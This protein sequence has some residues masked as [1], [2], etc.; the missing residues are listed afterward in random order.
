MKGE[1]NREEEI[2]KNN[3]CKIGKSINR[4]KEAKKEI[5]DIKESGFFTKLFKRGRLNHLEAEIRSLEK[6]NDNTSS[7]QSTILKR[8]GSL[9]FK[10]KSIEE[11]INKYN[12]QIRNLSSEDLKSQID[13]SINDLDILKRRCLDGER[14]IDDVPKVVSVNARII[15]ATLS[16]CHIDNDIS[17]TNFDRV[18][19][20]EASM[21]SLPLLFF[22]GFRATKSICIFGDPKQLAP[23]CI[24]NKE[25]VRKWFAKDIYKYAGLDNSSR[26]SVA[27]LLTQR[28]MPPELGSLISDLFYQGKLEHDW[29]DETNSS[30]AWMG[31]HRFALLDTADQGPF[32]SRHEIG[33]GYSRLN[34]VHAVIALNILKEA[35]SSGL[36]ASQMA[37]I[38]PY[39]AQAEFFGA[40]VLQNRTILKSGFLEE[41]RWGTVHRFQGGEAK[42][43][44]YD[45][46]ESPRELPTRLTGGSE[47]LNT[48]DHEIDDASRLHCVALS[49]AKFQLI[50]LANIRWLKGN[51]AQELQ[52]V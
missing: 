44:A 48:E 9:K 21:A 22:V 25:E 15:F 47:K 34:V 3:D 4:I 40:L 1:I 30:L 8:I 36:K 31:D 28:R 52:I 6:E 5:Q 27:E 10:I 37:Y 20:D 35:E 39:R 14:A 41:L 26:N 19:I 46:C 2:Y 50:I 18:F 33:R 32:C 16:R 17:M 51:A 49:R 42:L 11:D 23:I 43:I 38:T 29:E 45:P 7:E 24:S 13:S 12:P